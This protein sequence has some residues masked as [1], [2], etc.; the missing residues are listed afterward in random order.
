M[1]YQIFNVALLILVMW[2]SYIT[3]QNNGQLIA[4]Q[5]TQTTLQTQAEQQLVFQQGMATQLLEMKAFIS[6][7]QQAEQ[8]LKKIEAEQA[9]QQ[10]SIA[11][12][13]T[14]SDL[15]AAELLQKEKKFSDAAALLKASKDSIWQAG[16]QYPTHKEKLQGLMQPIDESLQQWQN[17]KA[18]T[19]QPIYQIVG[20]VLKT[21]TKK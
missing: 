1:S 19:I 5:N 12:Y 20:T 16:D 21:V 13:K 3:S 14:Y 6:K 15:L 7:Q 17:N 4:L 11:L 18:K 8:Q 10:H 9:Q 2:L